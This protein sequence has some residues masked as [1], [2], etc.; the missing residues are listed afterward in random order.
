M[1]PTAYML[2]LSHEIIST[3]CTTSAWIRAF[4]RAFLFRHRPQ[5][6][7]SLCTGLTCA[8]DVKMYSHSVGGA[9]EAE[10]AAEAGSQACVSESRWH[11]RPRTNPQTLFSRAK[12]A[13]HRLLWWS[14]LLACLSK[15]STFL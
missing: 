15:R 3:C 7:K 1:S 11:F 8:S 9:R 10:I 13:R 14:E 12:L 2:P 4:P 5:Q 6:G